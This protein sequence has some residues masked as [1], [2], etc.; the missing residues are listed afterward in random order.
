MDH[1]NV[2]V[3]FGADAGQADLVVKDGHAREAKAG[4][5]ATHE[6]QAV[7][8]ASPPQLASA[9]AVPVQQIG[10]GEHARQDTDPKQVSFKAPCEMEVLEPKVEPW[11]QKQVEMQALGAR[12]HSDVDSADGGAALGAE[13]RPKAKTF[14]QNREFIKTGTV[15]ERMEA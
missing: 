9:V 4:G 13:G 1:N 11:E 8:A 5:D 10:V 6:L 2:D 3:G 15:R 12:A 7:A 14:S